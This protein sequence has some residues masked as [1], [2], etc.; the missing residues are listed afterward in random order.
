MYQS[1]GDG[2]FAGR[3]QISISYQNPNNYRLFCAF[4][5]RL[6]PV[7][8][9]G[10]D[11]GNVGRRSDLHPHKQGRQLQRDHLDS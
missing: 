6:R 9:A 2:T 11:C 8:K 3:L 1:Q 5:Q 10:A 4:Y 7:I